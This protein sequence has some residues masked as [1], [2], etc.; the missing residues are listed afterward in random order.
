L[1]ELME[2][3]LTWYDLQPGHGDEEAEY[4]IGD[5]S[6]FAFSD[7]PETPWAPT[8]RQT[9]MRTEYLDNLGF[10]E[11]KSRS[12]IELLGG[13]ITYLVGPPRRVRVSWPNGR[14]VTAASVIEFYDRP[15]RRR[16]A[17]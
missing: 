3:Q 10:H 1:V 14:K 16:R 6:K 9:Q 5:F 7:Q 15:A 11:R 17:A 12:T 4:G 8:A 2:S 13:K